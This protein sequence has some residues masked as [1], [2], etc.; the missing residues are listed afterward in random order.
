MAKKA[1]SKNLKAAERRAEAF[2][3][4]KQGRSYSAIGSA[5]GCSK[6]YAHRMVQ[7]ELSA[8]ERLTETRAASLRALESER[9]DRAQESIWTEI[10]AG[11]LGAVSTFLR[12]SERRS[13]L[14]GL[15]APTSIQHTGPVPI[16][17]IEPPPGDDPPDGGD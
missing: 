2:R 15:D 14:L 1:A 16:T 12:I 10:E 4:R 11:N 6:Q 9:L 5:L 17:F 8:I 3:L 7:K 13:K